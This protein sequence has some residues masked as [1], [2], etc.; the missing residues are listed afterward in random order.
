MTVIAFFYAPIRQISATLGFVLL[1]SPVVAQ[2]VAPLKGGEAQTSAVATPAM[3]VQS[4]SDAIF[5][6]QG[7][8][9]ILPVAGKIAHIEVE[10]SKVIQATIND[11]RLSIKANQIG[12]TRITV[13]SD[14]GTRTLQIRV[15]SAQFAAA[16]NSIQDIAFRNSGLNVQ[17][18]DSTLEVTG[19]APSS[20]IDQLRQIASDQAG[21]LVNV[22]PGI[23]RT[24][25]PAASAEAVSYGNEA[26]TSPAIVIP[27][28][29]FKTLSIRGKIAR[30]EVGDNKIVHATTEDNSLLLIAKKVGSTQI[31]VW[32]SSET[33][34]KMRAFP[35]QVV[36]SPVAIQETVS[37][38]KIS[39]A[40]TPSKTADAIQVEDQPIIIPLGELKT[41]PIGKKITRIAV[42]N[43]KIVSTTTIGNNLLLIAEQ[44]GSTQIMVWSSGGTRTFWV[45]TVHPQFA[46]ARSLLQEIVNHNS[47]LKLQEVNS[48]LVVTGIAHTPVISQLENIAANLPDTLINVQPDQG[49]AATQSVLFRLHFIEVKKSFL[50]NIGVQWG[51][52]MSGPVFGVQAARGNGIY[53]NIMPYDGTTNLL[54]DGHQFYNV[55]GRTS[56]AFV[57]LA[58]VLN[59]S[60]K[61]GVTDGDVRVLASPELTAK[62]GGQAN[63]E[64]GGEVP[65]PVSGAFGSTSVE[66]K[67]YGVL[68][69][70]Q[71]TVDVDGVITAKIST[72]L[73]Q[74]DPAVSVQGIPG[75]LTRS[76][77]TE[78]S[79]QAGDVFVISGL[80]N[81]ELSNSIDKVPGLAN[82]PIIGRLFSS[83]DYRNQRSDLVVLVETELINKGT[84]MANDILQRGQRNMQQF[85]ALSRQNTSSGG[86]HPLE[87]NREP[88]AT[89]NPESANPAL[90]P[91]RTAK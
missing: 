27:L 81:G 4:G 13:W 73:S 37:A 68:M 53:R 55:E 20:V 6:P 41:L 78:I 22:K 39:A 67:P 5:I 85:Q 1:V 65:I 25:E 66:F 47:G 80:L 52:S 76:S 74:I 87:L 86:R 29:E 36:R 3:Q 62:S 83:D 57:G 69:K 84:G 70:I 10:N 46:A 28:G 50:Q 75:F 32:D 43:G 45:Q 89:A 15:V 58:S 24:V 12:G 79:V 51:S 9:R 44:I 19:I 16:R 91:W 2:P 11:N 34:W 17:D 61:L 77:S 60:I 38:T 72:E 7:A 49:S 56:G 63:L 30:I 33:P 54:E 8:V 59:S 21:I 48:R 64:V 31:M 23:M 88:P 26:V 14:Q 42:G 35:V 40:A 18:G 71:P 82:I 90:E